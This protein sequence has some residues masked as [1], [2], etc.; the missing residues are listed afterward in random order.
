MNIGYIKMWTKSRGLLVPN[1]LSLKA[2]AQDTRSNTKQ[3][4]EECKNSSTINKKNNDI[5]Y[6]NNETQSIQN[7]KA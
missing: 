7:K 4:K 2:L 3:F 6:S 5:A 1:N